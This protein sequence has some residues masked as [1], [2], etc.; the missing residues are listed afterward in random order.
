M[1]KLHERVKDAPFLNT[2]INEFLAP[3]AVSAPSLELIESPPAA[4]QRVS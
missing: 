2:S 4:T 1:L 3:I